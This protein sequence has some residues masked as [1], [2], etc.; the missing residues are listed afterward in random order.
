MVTDVLGSFGSV[1]WGLLLCLYIV[2]FAQSSCVL[3]DIRYVFTLCKWLKTLRWP[4]LHSCSSC[5]I[6]YRAYVCVDI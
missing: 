3:N 4:K 6:L 2:L 5:S 1:S